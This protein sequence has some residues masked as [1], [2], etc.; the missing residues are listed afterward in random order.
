MASSFARRLSAGASRATGSDTLG[1]AV[2]GSMVL[3][4]G[5]LAAWQ[6][7]RYRWKCDLV[8]SRKRVLA[9]SPRALEAV[10]EHEPSPPEFTRV[11]V[12]GRLDHEH[13]MLVG[14][15][16][17]PA[18]SPPAPSGDVHTGWLVLTPLHGERV[19]VLVNRGWVPRDKVAA[20]E[21][22]R[23]EVCVEGVVR[24]AE[25]PGSFALPNDPERGSYFWIDVAGMALDAELFDAVPL[26]VEA[27]ARSDDPKGVWPRP[28]SASS[29]VS[30]RVEP[31]MHLVYAGTWAT[32]CAASAAMVALRFRR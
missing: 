4:T 6:A 7:Q 29:L 28:R 3:G 8:E 19:S 25:E 1:R 5:G 23:G 24:A 15:R 20:I 31:P 9:A 2:F 16:S 30:F 12:S 27:T 18:G 26:L 21:Q 10:V 11:V 13:Q 32:L 14:P 22:P 17:P